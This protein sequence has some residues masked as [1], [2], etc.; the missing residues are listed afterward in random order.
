VWISEGNAIFCTTADPRI[1]SAFLQAGKGSLNPNRSPTHATPLA[2]PKRRGTGEH[3][4]AGARR[5]DWP[6]QK[7]AG[8]YAEAGRR[9][10]TGGQEKQARTHAEEKQEWGRIRGSRRGSAASGGGATTTTTTKNSGTTGIGASFAFR[11]EPDRHTTGREMQGDISSSAWRYIVVRMEMYH[12]PCGDIIVRGVGGKRRDGCSLFPGEN[13][14]GASGNAFSMPF[15]SGAL[16][17]KVT[18]ATDKKRGG[19]IIFFLI[20]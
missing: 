7:R 16:S 6:A 15:R 4:Q 5:G 20:F 8:E 13:R 12:R 1:V 2:R 3:G 18:E 10:R 17:S 9:I 14:C 11:L 19:G